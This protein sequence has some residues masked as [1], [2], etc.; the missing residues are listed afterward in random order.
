M[1]IILLNKKLKDYPKEWR[2]KEDITP[3]II[4]QNL[5]NS[6]RPEYYIY[7]MLCNGNILR[8]SDDIIS[9]VRK[10]QSLK[11]LSDKTWKRIIPI[12]EDALRANIEYINV[13]NKIY[14][15][16]KE[17]SDKFENFDIKYTLE[18]RFQLEFWQGKFAGKQPNYF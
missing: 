16:I 3:S 5:E 15:I 13:L 8:T 9:R 11:I 10:I 4:K 7:D 6:D 2:Y 18:E 1:E 17:Y 12:I 14:P